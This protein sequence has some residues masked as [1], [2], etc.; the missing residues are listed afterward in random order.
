MGKTYQSIVASGQSF[1][2]KSKQFASGFFLGRSITAQ[3]RA[4][5]L[6]PSEKKTDMVFFSKS[7]PA[8]GERKDH[9]HRNCNGN[10]P[11]ARMEIGGRRSAPDG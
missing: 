4:K 2:R 9:V 1:V 3:S 7:F 10:L 8:K 11:A 6:K 5:R